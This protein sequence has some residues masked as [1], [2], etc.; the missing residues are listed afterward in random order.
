MKIT[1]DI[2]RFAREEGMDTTA[3]I[4]VGMKKMADEFREHG[5]ELYVDAGS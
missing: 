4:D 5:S 2:R 3:A 1:E